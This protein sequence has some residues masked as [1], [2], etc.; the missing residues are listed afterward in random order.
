MWLPRMIDQLA[1]VGVHGEDDTPFSLGQGQH[2]DVRHAPIYIACKDHVMTADL[3]AGRDGDAY[4]DVRQKPQ[5]AHVGTGK[6]TG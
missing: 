5:R 2:V 1:K 6:S 3:Q 4:V